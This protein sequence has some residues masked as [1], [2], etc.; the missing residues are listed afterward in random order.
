MRL[1]ACLWYTELCSCN[2][3]KTIQQNKHGKR[4]AT[5]VKKML[6][7]I[8]KQPS[9]RVQDVQYFLCI[10]FLCRCINKHLRKTHL[11]HSIN[12]LLNNKHI[13][14][15]WGKVKHVAK[16]KTNGYC[17]HNNNLK[18]YLKMFCHGFQKFF[19]MWS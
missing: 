19:H 6:L 17:T 2:I 10:F 5:K 7:L 15:K 16:I 13:T 9:F 3:T 8:P 18:T 1:S 14:H 12:W 4:T 11:S